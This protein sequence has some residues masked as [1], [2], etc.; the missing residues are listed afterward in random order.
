MSDGYHLRRVALLDNVKQVRGD[1]AR[2]VVRDL[3]RLRRAAV[4]E[5]VWSYNTVARL[6]EERDLVTPI[7]RRRWEAVYE[8][9]GWKSF[10]GGW[11]DEGSIYM[12][13]VDQQVF[14]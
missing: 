2:L 11:R 10:V 13:R 7:V 1:L 14:V 3:V 9:N 12:S 4:P 8:E 6:C 5:Q